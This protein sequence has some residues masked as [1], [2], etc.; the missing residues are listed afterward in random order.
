MRQHFSDG[1]ELYSTV[2]A[3]IELTLGLLMIDTVEKVESL[4]SLQI[5]KTQTTSSIDAN[6]RRRSI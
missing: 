3:K 1:G 6:Y 4:T 2:G 5:Y